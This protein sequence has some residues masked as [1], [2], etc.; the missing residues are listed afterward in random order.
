MANGI[1]VQA[2]LEHWK[3]DQLSEAQT[4]RRPTSAVDVPLP[5]LLSSHM[6][7]SVTATHAKA[8]IRQQDIDAIVS[9]AAS[10]MANGHLQ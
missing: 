1:G 4:N 6:E 5:I 3:P 7:A 9:P 2:P 8:K 10:A